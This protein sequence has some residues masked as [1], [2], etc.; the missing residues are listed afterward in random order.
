MSWTTPVDW[1]T[2]SDPDEDDFNEQIR[3]NLSWLKNRQETSCQ[4]FKQVINF[5]TIMTHHVGWDIQGFNLWQLNP[6]A[7]VFNV[8]V[9]V[10]VPWDSNS[11]S[12]T[13]GDSTDRGGFFSLSGSDL[14]SLGWKLVE[15]NQKGLFLYSGGKKRFKSYE[16]IAYGQ[17]NNIRGMS[18]AGRLYAFWV[19]SAPDIEVLI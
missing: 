7:I 19:C 15:A 5:D 18:T 11:A 1:T 13:M 3:D 17:G 10:V 8:L 6:P 14:T 4:I 16:A 2:I 12:I 9:Y